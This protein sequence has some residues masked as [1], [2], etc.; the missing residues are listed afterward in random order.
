MRTRVLHDEVR[1]IR[2]PGRNENSSSGGLVVPDGQH[3]VRLSSRTYEQSHLLTHV[4]RMTRIQEGQQ[5]LLGLTRHRIFET[6]A[7]LAARLERARPKRAI[8]EVL[9][10]R[11]AHRFRRT[12]R[13]T[14]ELDARIVVVDANHARHA[15]ERRACDA[16]EILE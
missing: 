10:A 12:A 6:A 15:V 16:L 14:A 3:T 1:D 7:G 9:L 13:G 2:L 4:D 11:L 8:D 5:V